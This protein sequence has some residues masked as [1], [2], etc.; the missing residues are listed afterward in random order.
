[1]MVQEEASEEHHQ[2]GGKDSIKSTSA[3]ERTPTMT[4]LPTS[5][6]IIPLLASLYESY[7][8]AKSVDPSKRT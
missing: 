1:M 3:P 6:H 8:F 5:T 7:R 4:A 2:T